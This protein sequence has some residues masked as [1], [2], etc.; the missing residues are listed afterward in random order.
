MIESFVKSGYEETA[1]FILFN[2]YIM[3][4]DIEV[5]ESIFLVLKKGLEIHLSDLQESPKKTKKKIIISHFLL[6]LQN[7]VAV[8]YTLFSYSGIN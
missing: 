7:I 1:Y 8:T 6:L 4:R 2:H 3:K 5:V